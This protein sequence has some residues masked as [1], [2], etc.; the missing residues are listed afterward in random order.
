MPLPPAGSAQLKYTKRCG[1]LKK[2]IDGLMAGAGAAKLNVNWEPLNSAW[3]TVLRDGCSGP[4]GF[5]YF[6]PISLK[7]SCFKRFSSVTSFSVAST[8]TRLLLQS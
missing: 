7:L 3:V 2:G 4:V 8:P 6:L 1:A 5:L